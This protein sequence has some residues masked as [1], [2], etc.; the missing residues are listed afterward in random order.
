MSVTDDIKNRLD[1]V[2]V[3][4]SHTALQKSGSSYKST[5]PFHDEKTPS[6]FVFPE[7]Q[8]WR[9]FGACATGGDVYSFV[10]K[11]RNIGFG[12]ALRLLS[13]QT[14]IPLPSKDDNSDYQLVKDLNN[15][16]NAF[17]LEYLMSIRGARTREYLKKRNI[18]QDTLEK[19][20]LGLS[21][22]S[23][24]S[25]KTHLI[26]MGYS[27]EQ[28]ASAGLVRNIENGSV[29]DIF[30]NRLTIPIRNMNGELA[31]FGARTLSDSMPKYINSPKTIVFDKSRILY[32]LYLAKQTAVS[33]GLVVVEGYMDTITAH[34]NGFTNV[35][36]SMGTSLT[37]AQVSQITKLT[38]TVTMALDADSAGQQ[39]TLRSLESSWNVLQ[40]NPRTGTGASP[41]LNLQISILPEGQDPD[42]VIR[43]SPERWLNFTNNSID[44]FDY[45]LD[46]FA[47]QVDVK[48]P[49]GKAS[50][51]H[52]LSGFITNIEEPV[53]QDHYV[54]ILAR[55][56]SVNEDTIRASLNR[57]IRTSI[58]QRPK[59]NPNYQDTVSDSAFSK[60]DSD[61]IEEY[62]LASL[63]QDTTL[64]S[65]CSNISPDYFFR[66]EHKEI[67]TQIRNQ[68][69]TGKSAVDVNSLNQSL[70]EDLCNRVQSLL[71]KKLPSADRKTRILA[72]N[73]SIVRLEDRYLK[74]L[75]TEES[76]SVYEDGHA[77][78]ANTVNDSTLDTNYKIRMNEIS[79][80]SLGNMISRE[81]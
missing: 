68:I 76:N 71:A 52:K 3:I 59:I 70:P 41:N 17:F 21:P 36:A 46:A 6:F 72:L 11:S 40:N 81:R 80:N 78:L 35:V 27:T 50:L 77:I 12:E 48:T 2:D 34:Q 47:R 61:P 20:E 69:D 30:I 26:N 74:G 79:R 42:D 51:V 23:G 31:G 32:G 29:R 25:L 56:L 28:L 18:N 13:E 1:I 53:Q 64:I 15:S 8:S 63:L 57:N 22:S 43:E 16:A 33:D 24:E 14:G 38:D 45:I 9:C 54:Q 62:C 73:N 37:T 55:F 65:V 67:I 5:C 60:T 4:S 44:A 75:K 7:R 19:F 39:A 10:M 66:P 58:P 49:Y